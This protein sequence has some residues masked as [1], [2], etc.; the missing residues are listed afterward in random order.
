VRKSRLT[1]NKYPKDAASPRLASTFQ[2]FGATC[3][4]QRG[5]AIKTASLAELDTTRSKLRASDRVSV[6]HT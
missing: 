2:P 1:L 3:G 4:N 5:H 6:V